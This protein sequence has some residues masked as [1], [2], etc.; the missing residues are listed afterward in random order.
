MITNDKIL[1]MNS[2][3]YLSIVLMTLLTIASCVPTTMETT[4]SSKLRPADAYDEIQKLATKLATSSDPNDAEMLIEKSK[5]FINRH[6]KF[7]HADEVYYVLGITLVQ[8]D[9]VEEGIAILDELIRYYP[10][11]TYFASAS[12]ILGLAYD[13]ISM[14]DEADK[15]YTKL[16]NNSKYRDGKYAQTAQ[17][18]LQTDLADRRVA[19]KGWSDST[20]A[21][22]SANFVGQVAMDFEVTDL[23]GQPL[24]LEKY[25]GQVVLLDFWAT[26]CP[27]CLA[28][29]PNVKQT[30]AKYKNQ[31]FQIIGISWDRGIK[32]LEDY[33]EKEGIQWP[34]YYDND[35]R[36]SNMYQV[37]A[38]PS[39]FLIDGNGI[40][41]MTNLRGSALEAGVAQLVQENLG[42]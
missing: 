26:W 30:Y 19:F 36:I 29:M 27:P 21:F 34:Q 32:P 13:K 40:I 6:G 23:N 12:L 22:G 42:R 8:F 15:V 11:A 33:I 28:E 1:R 41:R 3:Y 16:M 10:V 31:K 20:E 4:G 14:H 17:K 9:R 18:L 39:T 24:S 37:R 35:S 25:R 5:V 2:L 7:K 38:I